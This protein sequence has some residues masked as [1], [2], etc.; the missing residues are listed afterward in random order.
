MKKILYTASCLILLTAVTACG[1]AP[2]Q[3]TQTQS[4]RTNGYGTLGTG[5]N[6]GYGMN[7]YGTLGTGNN[8][9]YGMNGFGTLGTGNYNGYGMNGFGTNGYGINN[10][11]YNGYGFN[12]FG[13][14]TYPYTGFYQSADTRMRGYANNGY[15]SLTSPNHAYNRELADRMTASAK[16]VKGVQS[17]TTVVYG[18][19]AVVGIEL[20]DNKNRNTIEREVNDA[21]V[22]AAPYHR[23]YVTSDSKMVP[24]VKGI[25]NNY[26][27]SSSN[28]N[29]MSGPNTVTGNLANVGSDF[30]ALVTDLGRT[31]T[32]PFR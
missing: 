30:G 21:V 10:Y 6:T 20:K 15:R 23:V 2:K 3:G 25:D 9:G 28:S 19:E 11:G 27:S 12:E 8:T 7:G 26:R 24:R 31:V 17:A 32:A 4:Y 1:T 16:K 22:K 5:N 14:A 13:R 18:N 29:M